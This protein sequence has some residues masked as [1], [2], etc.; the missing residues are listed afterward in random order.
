MPSLLHQQPLTH[1]AALVGLS[2]AWQL[3]EQELTGIP[4]VIFHNN[5][6]IQVVLTVMGTLLL[7]LILTV[8]LKLLMVVKVLQQQYPSL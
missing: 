7:E 5:L 8:L 2:H 4:I 6:L 1:Q 3:Q